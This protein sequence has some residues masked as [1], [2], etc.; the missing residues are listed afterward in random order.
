MSNI[1]VMKDSSEHILYNN[2][3][4]PLYVKTG[5]L[6]SFPHMEALCHWHEDVEFLIPINGHISYHVN[7]KDFYIEQDNAIFVNSKQMHYGYSSDGS[8]CEYICIVFK[9][10]LICTNPYLAEKYISP[11]IEDYNMSQLLLSKDNPEH[12]KIISSL[13]EIYQLYEKKGNCYELS[14]ISLLSSVWTELY[15][16][17]CNQIST[18]DYSISSDIPIQKQMVRF[19]YDNYTKKIS[20]NDI[21]HS[22]GISRT[23]CCQIFKKYLNK[24]P[25]DFLNSY[26][27]E[28]SMNLLRD[29]SL[30]ITEIAY[31][32]GFNNLSYYSEIFKHYKGCTPNKYRLNT[33][34]L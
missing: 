17:L 9:R 2:P 25:I 5:T 23:K 14:S 19:I 16:I 31:D 12:Q 7:D 21:S 32:C 24:T 22:G 8:D 10:S 34:K 18:V 30:S 15:H 28:I 26:R 13:K 1:R 11:I 29:T 4:L 6:S 20:L 3:S 33:S 27:L